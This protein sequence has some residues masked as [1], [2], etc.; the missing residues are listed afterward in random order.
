VVPPVRVGATRGVGVPGG[1]RGRR[2]MAWGCRAGGREGGSNGRS[3][4]WRIFIPG[5]PQWTW[6]QRGR[7]LVLLGSYVSAMAAGLFSWGTIGGMAMLAF[8]IGAHVASVADV[9]RQAAF[10]GFGRWVP[11]ISA[12]CGV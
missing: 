12:T 3:S 6:S 8:A 1:A 9:I 4:G 5:Y 10:P 2:P 7:G 11:W